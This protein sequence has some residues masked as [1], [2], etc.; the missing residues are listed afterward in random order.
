M[1]SYMILCLLKVLSA[2]H[3]MFQAFKRRFYSDVLANDD[4]VLQVT[5][6]DLGTQRMSILYKSHTVRWWLYY[7][8]LMHPCFKPTVPSLSCNSNNCV[9]IFTKG[10]GRILLRMYDNICVAAADNQIMFANIGARDVTHFITDN[11]TIMTS[12]VLAVCDIAK[13]LGLTTTDEPLTV[14]YND[15]TTLTLRSNDKVK[16]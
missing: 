15:L 6:Y 13:I 4:V 5:A 16:I 8:L 10:L 9:L 14:V 12:G 7:M 1:L 3:R 2:I 11:H